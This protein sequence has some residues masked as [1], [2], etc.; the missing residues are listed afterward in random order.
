MGHYIITQV[1]SIILPWGKYSYKRL[2]I[3]P[4]GSL[5]IKNIYF[6]ACCREC[7]SHVLLTSLLICADVK[8]LVGG[9]AFAHANY[10]MDFFNF[11]LT[12]CRVYHS[13]TDEFVAMLSLP[14][15]LLGPMMSMHKHS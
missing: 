7:K 13:D 6:H 11:H 8:D 14:L 15:A 10:G 5:Y 2:H 3:G 12:N 4:A 1:N 9:N